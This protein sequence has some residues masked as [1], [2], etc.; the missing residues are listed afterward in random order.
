MEKKKISPK[1]LKVNSKNVFEN[2][3]DATENA[4]DDKSLANCPTRHELECFLSTNVCKTTECDTTADEC[5]P[6][7]MCETKDCYSK[8]GCIETQTHLEACC[9]YTEEGDCPHTT[10]CESVAYTCESIQV[11]LISKVTTK[12]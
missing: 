4:K 7:A 8:V 12:K 11:C 2:S 3:P 1:D 6:T 10:D 9:P 5:W